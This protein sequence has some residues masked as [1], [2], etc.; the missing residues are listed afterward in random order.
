MKNLVELHNLTLRRADKTVLTIP[1]LTIEEGEVLAVVGPNGAGKSTFLLTLAGLIPP[2]SGKLIF[3]G[4]QFEQWRRLDYRRQVALVLQEPLLLDRS[5]L[6]NLLLGLRFRKI[7]KPEAIQRSMEWLNR[8]GIAELAQR[9]AR[10]LSGG[11]AQRVSLARALVLEPRLLLLD[12]PFAALDPPTRSELLQ[13]FVAL[14]HQNHTTTIFVT[15]HLSEAALLG[16]RIAVFSEG[17]L[18]QI[19][20]FEEICEQPADLAVAQFVRP[21][22]ARRSTDE[23]DGH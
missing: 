11:E 21:I 9:K 23:A 18:R 5:V 15:H 19:G 20:S 4:R 22:L 10:S 8:L 3:A 2:L 1:A 16:N 13:E 7:P 17:T 6:D 14:L 12:E